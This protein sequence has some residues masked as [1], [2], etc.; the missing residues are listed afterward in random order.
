MKPSGNLRA[1]IN[2]NSADDIEE[3]VASAMR[4][5]KK[6]L[7]GDSFVQRAYSK[8]GEQGMIEMLKPLVKADLTV[9]E[10][11]QVIDILKVVIKR[12]KLKSAFSGVEASE[13]P[14]AG[15]GE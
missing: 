6:G 3:T 2:V 5:I 10:A 14:D 8:V 12:A 9:D 1:T 11:E 13:K 7:G 15:G 4:G